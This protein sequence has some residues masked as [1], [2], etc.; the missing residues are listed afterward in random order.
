MSKK[1]KNVIMLQN[2]NK[3]QL[4]TWQMAFDRE[5]GAQCDYGYRNK[6]FVCQIVENEI[7][8]HAD[9]TSMYKEN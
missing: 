1:V 5:V 3:N 6:S 8:K 4:Q 2:Y 7:P 9:V